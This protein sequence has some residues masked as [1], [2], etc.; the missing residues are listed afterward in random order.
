MRKEEREGKKERHEE[1]EKRESKCYEVQ[2][3][4]QKLL[5]LGEELHKP[6]FSG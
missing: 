4:I 5:L 2:P 3:T 1:G 6:N